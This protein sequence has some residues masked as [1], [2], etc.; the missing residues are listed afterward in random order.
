MSKEELFYKE[1][2]SKYLDNTCT[3]S[4]ADGLF[5]YLEKNSSNKVLLQSLNEEYKNLSTGLQARGDYSNRVLSS[6]L[7]SIDTAPVVQMQRRRWPHMVAAA[8]IIFVVGIS[9]Y[10]LFK[11]ASSPGKLVA[12]QKDNSQRFKN[13]IKPG[14]DKAILV[15]AN[16]QSIVLD[17]AGNGMVSQQGST[18]ILKLNNGQLSYTTGDTP[19]SGAAEILYNSIVTPHGGQYQVTLPDGTMVWLN[20][21]SSLRFPTAFIGKER[22]V[23][24]TGEAYFE[25]A[26]NTAMPFIV[27]INKG[28]A[29]EVLGTHFNVMAYGDE[30]TIK[31]TLLEGAINLK[32]EGV[33]QRLKPGQ[34]AQI[35]QGKMNVI[36]DVDVERAIAWKNG[37][38]DFN[39]DAVP[40]IMRQLSR[41]YDIDVEYE[42]KVPDGHYVGSVRR[43]SNI[44]AVV[45]MLELAGDIRFELQGKKLIVKSSVK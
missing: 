44:S 18:K 9:S 42:G 27:I 19:N 32:N 33:V 29:V 37:L 23:E 1:L 6:L 20:A 17:S 8:A 22:K 14:G 21:S 45:K 34:Q 10:F 39:D 15:L 43:K 11:P 4:E 12:I 36:N 25:V 35:T 24:I 38:F 16:G 40:D 2:L 13:D 28:A 41:W 26:K 30:K 5:S 7:K 3:P 31:T